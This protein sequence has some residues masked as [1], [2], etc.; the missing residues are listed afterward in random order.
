MYSHVY[1]WS[2]VYLEDA[3]LMNVKILLQKM[4]TVYIIL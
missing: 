4:H 3:K 1:S 2:V